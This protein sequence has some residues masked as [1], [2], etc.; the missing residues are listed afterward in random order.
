MLVSQPP[1]K[2][3]KEVFVVDDDVQ[4]IFGEMVVKASFL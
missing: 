2:D 1:G 3:K 4:G